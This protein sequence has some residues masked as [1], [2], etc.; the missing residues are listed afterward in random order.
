MGWVERQNV[1]WVK[2]QIRALQCDVGIE[3]LGLGDE[4]FLERMTSL[5]F[6]TWAT[7]GRVKRVL[8]LIGNRRIRRLLGR[9]IIALR[10][11]T[12]I[13]LTLRKQP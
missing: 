7:L 3:V 4:L 11:W 8:D 2:R 12:P 10:G 6:A 9:L 13:V 1:G 5:D